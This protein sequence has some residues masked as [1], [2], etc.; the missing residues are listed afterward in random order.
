MTHHIWSKKA[1]CIF[2]KP[3]VEFHQIYSLVHLGTAIFKDKS[4][5]LRW[6]RDQIWSGGGAYTSVAACQVPSSFHHFSESWDDDAYIAL[7]LC[8]SRAHE[9]SLVCHWLIVGPII[10]SKYNSA[11]VLVSKTVTSKCNLFAC[12]VTLF[13]HQNFLSIISRHP[14]FVVHAIK[15]DVA[16]IPGGRK[17][18]FCKRLLPECVPTIVGHVVTCVGILCRPV[19]FRVTICYHTVLVV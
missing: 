19:W 9:C 2:H 3:L 17:Q 7:C 10:V 1:G 18:V 4:Q 13:T 5:K 12:Y 11:M 8:I 15:T 6:R 14:V 16:R